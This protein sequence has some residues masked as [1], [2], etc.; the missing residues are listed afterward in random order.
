MGDHAQAQAEFAKTRSLTQAADKTVME[1]LRA[2]R[3]QDASANAN[4]TSSNPQQP[5]P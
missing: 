2:S 1:K 4:A 5:N 3:A